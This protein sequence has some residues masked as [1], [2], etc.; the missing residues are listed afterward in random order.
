MS[1]SNLINSQPSWFSNLN[2]AAADVSSTYLY[3][4]VTGFSIS[5]PFNVYRYRI[6]GTKI[7]LYTT[8]V[9]GIVNIPNSG[10]VAASF[11]LNNVPYLTPANNTVFYSNWSPGV[12]QSTPTNIMMIFSNSSYQVV[13]VNSTN[14]TPEIWP[15]GPGSNQ[16]NGPLW[17]IYL[18]NN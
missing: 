11:K 16:V 13:P 18:A 1:L 6:P 4:Q 5:Q 12:S 17:G 9:I 7:V 8:D 2:L 10:S 15:V 3:N 14:G